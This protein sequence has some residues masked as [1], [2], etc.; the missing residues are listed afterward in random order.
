[1]HLST[2]SAR[3]TTDGWVIDATKLDGHLEQLVGL[4]TSRAKAVGWIADHPASWWTSYI[5]ENGE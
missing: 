2:F 5:T 3:K 1:M 4:Y